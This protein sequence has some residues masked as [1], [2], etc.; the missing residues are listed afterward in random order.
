VFKRLEEQVFLLIVI[1]YLT[2]VEVWDPYY[3][4]IFHSLQLIIRLITPQL[5]IKD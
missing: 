4:L 3:L 2:V 1:L 5:K